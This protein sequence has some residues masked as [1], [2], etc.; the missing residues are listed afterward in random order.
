VRRAS[1][2]RGLTVD[3]HLQVIAVPWGTIAWDLPAVGAGG[4][5]IERF[6]LA[7]SLQAAA[8][9][10]LHGPFQAASG[11]VVEPAHSWALWL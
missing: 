2:E 9:M 1:R 8:M 10:S 6:E 11:D 3:E 7:Q 5:R 4:H